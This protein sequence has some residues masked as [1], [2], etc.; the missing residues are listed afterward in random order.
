VDAPRVQAAKSLH[1]DKKLPVDSI[2]Q[3]LKI[4]RPTLYLWLA[5]KPGVPVG[6]GPG[7]AK[8]EPNPVEGASLAA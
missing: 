1:A 3:T 6:K 8:I 2:C 4:S 7:R 5:P